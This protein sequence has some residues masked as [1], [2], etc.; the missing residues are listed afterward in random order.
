[1]KYIDA[2]R[3]ADAAR[4]LRVRIRELA[5]QLADRGRPVRVMEVC[6]THTMA[7]ARYAIR[8]ALPENV[9]L[10]SGPGCPVCVTPPGYID[11]AVALAERG[12]TIATFGDMLNVP[13]SETSLAR[14][15]AEG[16]RVEVC[17]SPTRACELAMERPDAEIVF[18]GVG[19]ETTIGPVVSL[20]RQALERDMV[21]ARAPDGSF[22]PR[23]WHE[24]LQMGSNSDVT[25]GEVWTTATWAIVLGCEP[26]KGGRPGLPVWLGR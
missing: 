14:C 22:Q 9:Q 26:V 24:S 1:M 10:V 18:L 8:E 25:F 2:F 13:G 3:N 21:L 11:V 12:V 7:I 23:P 20:V 6:G 15:R 5:G 4:A 19:F 17:Y 16:A